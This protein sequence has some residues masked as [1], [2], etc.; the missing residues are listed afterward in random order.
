M[1]Q[2]DQHEQQILS[3]VKAYRRQNSRS[4]SY[5]EICRAVGL[6]SKDHV[7]R[8]LRRLKQRGALTFTPGVSRSIVPLKVSRRRHNSGNGTLPFPTLISDGLAPRPL[9]QDDPITREIESIAAAM[10]ED[11]RDVYILQVRGEA[12]GD[13]LLSEGDLVLVKHTPKALDGD[14]VAVWLKSKRKTMLKYIYR[15]NGYVRLQSPNPNLPPDLV[16]LSEIEIRG[17]V[18][19]IVRNAEN[20]QGQKG[21]SNPK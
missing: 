1:T 8:D 15:E 17:P 21:V 4:P 2:R 19:A 12:S 9:S 16:E 14:M 13:A 20:S 10:L 3:F 6:S 5:Q 7:A 18:L 11:V